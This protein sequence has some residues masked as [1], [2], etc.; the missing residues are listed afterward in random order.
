MRRCRGATLTAAA[1][2]S[3][4]AGEVRALF[5]ACEDD[6]AKKPAMA[7]RDAAILALLYGSGLRRAD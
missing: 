5:A 1:R 4:A 2:P 6:D 7:A 3:V